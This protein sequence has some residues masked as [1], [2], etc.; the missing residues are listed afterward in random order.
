MQAP[1]RNKTKSVAD[2]LQM[3]ARLLSALATQE[4]KNERT[5]GVM[6][7]SSINALEHN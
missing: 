6:I 1:H 3:K 4:E 2:I 5:H 7:L